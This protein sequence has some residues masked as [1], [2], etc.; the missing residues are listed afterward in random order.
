MRS[1]F[2]QET[3]C[4]SKDL[5]FETFFLH[6]FFS[7]DFPRNRSPGPTH[8][9]PTY[10]LPTVWLAGRGGKNHCSS[11]GLRRS[12]IGPVP[13]VFFHNI[14]NIGSRFKKNMDT[15]ME[16]PQ[17]KGCIL[18]PFI[19]EPAPKIGAIIDHGGPQLGQTVIFR[20]MASG[21]L[22]IS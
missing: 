12:S 14:S 3:E 9:V 11:T 21:F 19:P 5:S 1:K 15:N 2:Q 4:N 6:T 16:Y 13:K 22:Q 7:Q 8:Q 10:Q 20:Y 17:K 18:E